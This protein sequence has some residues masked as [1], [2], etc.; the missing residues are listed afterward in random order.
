MTCF[1]M[2]P[3]MFLL[4]WEYIGPLVDCLF[5]VFMHYTNHRLEVESVG[6]VISLKLTNLLFR[7]FLIVEEIG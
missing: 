5:I 1:G 4:K 7:P 2:G 3:L 6:T